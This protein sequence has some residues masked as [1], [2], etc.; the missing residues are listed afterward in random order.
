M[1]AAQT[2]GDL[3]RTLRKARGKNQTELAACLRC[4]QSYAAKIENGHHPAS[5]KQ[6]ESLITYLR[7]D[8]P[9]R[10]RFLA[11]LAHVPCEGRKL[12]KP[13]R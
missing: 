7:P 12:F 9:A 1:P 6:I 8:N 3:L 13:L 11:Y 5:P 10:F 4:S 2:F